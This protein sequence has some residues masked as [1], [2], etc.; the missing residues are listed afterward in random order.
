LR[1]IAMKKIRRKR[2]I[3]REKLREL[4][5]GEVEGS[6]WAREFQ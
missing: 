4:L 5:V 2:E 1:K 3:N 6:K